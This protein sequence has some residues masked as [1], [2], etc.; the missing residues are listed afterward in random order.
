MI[1][2]QMLTADFGFWENWERFLASISDH[3]RLPKRYTQGTN[4]PGPMGARRGNRELACILARGTPFGRVRVLPHPGKQQCSLLCI[5]YIFT[6]LIHIFH[7]LVHFCII[8][9]TSC[10]YHI[11]LRHHIYYHIYMICIPGIMLFSDKSEI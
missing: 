6:Y 2:L 7:V 3:S 10:M 5:I 8:I 4:T 1:T 11:H 9:L